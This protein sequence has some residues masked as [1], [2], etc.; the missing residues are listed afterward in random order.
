MSRLAHIRIVWPDWLDDFLADRPETY[1]DDRSAMALAIALAR[2]NVRRGTGG[3]FGAVAFASASGRLLSVGVNLVVAA[4]TSIAHAEMLALSSA[5]Q[6]LGHHDLRQIPGGCTLA[7][8][9]EP[10][11]MCLGAV[12]WSGVSRL[13]CGAR[14][15]D[16]RAI[17]FDEGAK[18]ADWPAAL[19]RR[20]IVLVRDCR[21]REAKAVLEDY[22]ADGGPL[23]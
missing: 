20:G 23:Y 14:D 11:A 19:A 2:E 1:P 13:V 4:R 16:A 3:P 5:Q 6:R 9:T 15:R 8:S 18:P 22:R 10:C 21:R 7:T 12:P 17:G